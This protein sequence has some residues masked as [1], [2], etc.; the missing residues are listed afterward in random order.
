MIKKSTESA[1]VIHT[2]AAV[3][4]CHFKTVIAFNCFDLYMETFKII[5]F[6]RFRRSTEG[7]TQ[8]PDS[9]PTTVKTGGSRAK[10]RQK[11]LAA[12]TAAVGDGDVSVGGLP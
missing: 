10:T 3:V 5:R 11:V 7:C 4:G 6:L 12:A 8:S 2:I 9:V 1:T